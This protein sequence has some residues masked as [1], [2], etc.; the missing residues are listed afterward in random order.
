[1]KIFT[2][3]LL[4]VTLL[5]SCKKNPGAA[6]E[7][8]S[9]KESSQTTMTTNEPQHIR[10]QHILIGFQGSLP[11]KNVSRNLEDA[12][13]LA[14]TVFEKA[15]DPKTDFDA[16]VKENTDDRAPGIY[17]MSNAGVPPEGDEFPRNQMVPAFGD[18]G[19]KL[20]K[21]EVGLASYDK[22]TSPFGFHIIKRIN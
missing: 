14:E 5:T 21:G 19:F 2:I 18:V 4:S 8:A 7:S 10:V 6:S 15:K 22:A 9:T 11:G 20:Q 12:K 17:G 3:C 1:L 13:K 16:L